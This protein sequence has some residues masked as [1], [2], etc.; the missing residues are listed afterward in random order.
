M[1]LRVFF[2]HHRRLLK[3]DRVTDHNAG[4]FL[5]FQGDLAGHFGFLSDSEYEGAM[6]VFF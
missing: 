2:C 3:G 1:I 6:A 4:Y 5:A